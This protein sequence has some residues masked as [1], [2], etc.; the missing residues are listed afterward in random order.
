MQTHKRDLKL[1]GDIDPKCFNGVSKFVSSD[2]FLYPCCFV[3]TQKKQIVKWADQ[4]GYDI[5]DINLNKY[6][7]NEIVNGKFMKEFNSR[8]D[9]NVCQY[10]CGKNSYKTEL[11][12]HPKWEKYGSK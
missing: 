9:I 11:F 3:Y 2:G 10:H 8:F 7:H 6:T 12:G 1:I 5:Q 4:N